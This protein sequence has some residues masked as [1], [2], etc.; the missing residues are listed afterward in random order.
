MSTLPEKLHTIKDKDSGKHV[1][2]INKG[3][4]GSLL[5]FLNDFVGKTNYLHGET[6]DF[7]SYC[8]QYGWNYELEDLIPK[9]D[10][11][12][13]VELFADENKSGS[14]GPDCSDAWFAPAGY[15]R[16]LLAG[17]GTHKEESEDL[18]SKFW[19]EWFNRV[20]DS[21][22]ELYK[23][24]LSEVEVV[25]AKHFIPEEKQFTHTDWKSKYALYATPV[26]TVNIELS[27][28]NFADVNENENES[29]SINLDNNADRG[30]AVWG[31][32]LFDPN[33]Q[34]YKYP[35][36]DLLCNAYKR[37]FTDSQLE[38]YTIDLNNLY[39]NLADVDIKELMALYTNDVNWADYIKVCS[40][41]ST[42]EIIFTAPVSSLY[43]FKST[44]T[45]I[46]Y[47]NGIKKSHKVNILP[48]TLSYKLRCCDRMYE[49]NHNVKGLKVKT[50]CDL[51]NFV[52][53]ELFGCY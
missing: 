53:D 29:G 36:N 48:E 3:I 35:R 17:F 42:N 51:L 41:M 43:S 39:I 34:T 24:R 14:I 26:A 44:D 32:N 16:G 18:W 22:H 49:E 11:I 12:V 7:K 31:D 2:Y 37:C 8:A 19:D 9:D 47:K 6:R 38:V 23:H 50:Y 52:F 45:L 33:T 10:S 1:G 46:P 15:Q 27:F 25:S 28:Y 21:Q 20:V 13:T 30:I 5:I 4:D 40:I